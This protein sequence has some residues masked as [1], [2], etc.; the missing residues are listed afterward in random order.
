MISRSTLQ[1]KNNLVWSQ[2]L[3]KKEVV[4]ESTKAC[5]FKQMIVLQQPKKVIYYNVYNLQKKKP[6]SMSHKE[7]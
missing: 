1:Q 7:H 6:I 4:L 2:L 5:T 3:H